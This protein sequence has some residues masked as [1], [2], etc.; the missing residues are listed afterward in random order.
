MMMKHELIPLNRLFFA[1]RPSSVG[2]GHIDRE[3]GRWTVGAR[4]ILP[5]RRHVTL[6][7]LDDY[8]VLPKGLIEAMCEVGASI[9]AE[10]F[11][12][13]FVRI[14]GSHRSL[15][16]RP[17]GQDQRLVQLRK[18]ILSAMR[19][20][21]IGERRDYRFSPHMTLAYRDG[22]PSSETIPA[23][24]WAV[25]EL[26]LINSHVGRTHHKILGRWKLRDADEAQYRL[27]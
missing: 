3:L 4:N 12:I 11:P 25:D 22:Q 5:E 16:L 1:I 9:V 18:K 23:F 2:T 6:A 14:V 21:G 13:T 15:A 27:L 24:G 8:P 17:E 10:R 7:I 20:R 19:T 26:V